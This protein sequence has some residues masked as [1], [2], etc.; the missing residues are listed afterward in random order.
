MTLIFIFWQ[1]S[2]R[3]G[4][5]KTSR[6]TATQL[7][8][9]QKFYIKSFFHCLCFHSP[10][11]SAACFPHS[12][13]PDEQT[14]L[15]TTSF[16][17]TYCLTLPK[18]T[19]LPFALAFGPQSN[20]RISKSSF[21]HIHCCILMSFLFYDFGSSVLPFVHHEEVLTRSAQLFKLLSSI[22]HICY[23]SV[24]LM[25][26]FSIDSACIS[27]SPPCLNPFISISS[28]SP[29]FSSLQLGPPIF[30]SL[31]S[32]SLW[33]IEKGNSLHMHTGCAT[34]PE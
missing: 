30:V 5:Q 32:L 6:N 15:L 14:Q 12:A 3:P 28:S 25:P 20:F 21:L 9:N 18:M 27:S 34:F 11:T 19:T 22:S 8:S 1:S 13:D 31:S 23:P 4:L 16:S 33:C 24:G 26:F 17:Q 7:V 29:Y 10:H 2:H